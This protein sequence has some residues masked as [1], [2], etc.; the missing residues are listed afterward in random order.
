MLC[1]KQVFGLFECK[2]QKLSL[3]GQKIMVFDH[4]YFTQPPHHHTPLTIYY[5]LISLILSLFA[6]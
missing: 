6:S 2:L 4:F 1:D 5:L 3:W